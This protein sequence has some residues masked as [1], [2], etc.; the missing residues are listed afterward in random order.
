MALTVKKPWAGLPQ[1]PAAIDWGSSLVQKLQ[2]LVVFNGA[3]GKTDLVTKT[4]FTAGSAA[5]PGMGSLGLGVK[6]V[7]N[8]SGLSQTGRTYPSSE[9]GYTLLWSGTLHGAPSGSTPKLLGIASSNTSQSNDIVGLEFATAANFAI[10][11]KTGASFS[12]RSFTSSVPAYGPVTIVAVYDVLADVCRLHVNYLGVISSYTSSSIAGAAAPTIAG[13]EAFCLG[14]DIIEAASR[15]ANATVNLGFVGAGVLGEGEERK[16]ALSPWQIFTPRQRKIWIPTAGGATTHATSGDLVGQGAT[17]AGDATNFTPHSTSG[18]I[19]GQGATVSGSAAHIAIHGTS[20][21]IEGPG[22][23]IAGDAARVGAAVT[24][25]TSG[26]ISGAGA[27]ISGSAQNGTAT[28]AG[29]RH[30]P[31][32]IDVRGKIHEFATQ[33]GAN[34]FLK[35]LEPVEEKQIQAKAKRIVSAVVRTGNAFKPTELTPVKVISGPPELTAL[36]NMRAAIL[37]GQLNA[38]VNAQIQAEMQ[39][40]QD[41]ELAAVAVMMMME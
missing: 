26:A 38:L 1:V 23:V 8:N 37:Q 32:L 13:T 30:K 15:Y 21:A 17:I 24:H 25:E 16:L 27:E 19:S 6:Q 29:K 4:A 39:Q 28:G 22:A 31:I 33:Q 34:A 35:S 14:P 10:N 2:P 36:A 20:G 5:T 12:N 11:F 3:N 9:Q 40:L 7:A 41:D 18:A